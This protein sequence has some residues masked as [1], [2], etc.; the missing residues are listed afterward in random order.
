M[1]TGLIAMVVGG[2]VSLALEVIPGLKDKWA[3]WEWKPLSLLV[4]F[5]GVPVAIVALVCSFGITLP[6]ISLD[7]VNLSQT[8]VNAI[9]LGF[10]SFLGN[11]G[12][13]YTATHRLPNVRAR[14]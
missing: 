9:L 11:Q 1:T 12:T 7:C 14:K 5:L 13:F 3:N 2:L 6:E 10:I 8:Y 4:G